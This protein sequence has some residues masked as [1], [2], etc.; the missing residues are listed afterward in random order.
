MSPNSAIPFMGSQMRR[1]FFYL[2]LLG[3]A[4]SVMAHI[5]SFVIPNI[6]K[7]FPLIWALHFGVFIVFFPAMLEVKKR[8]YLEELTIRRMMNPIA[9][10]KFWF[11]NTPGWF[12]IITF[13]TMAYSS[14]YAQMQGDNPSINVISWFSSV[15]LV[16]Y[17]LSASILFPYQINSETH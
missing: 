17:T 8:A 11:K 6:E 14:I 10:F 3:F 16:F 4:L 13:V 5:T 7:L 1:L 2:A 12:I 9:F 15:W